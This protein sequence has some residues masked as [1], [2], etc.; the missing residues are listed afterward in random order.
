MNTSLQLAIRDRHL[1]RCASRIPVPPI[2][3]ALQ[4]AGLVLDHGT[5]ESRIVPAIVITCVFGIVGYLMHGV[6]RSGAVAGTLLAFIIYVGLGLGG[7]LSL[8]AVFGI[9]WVTTRIG[10]TRKRQLGLAEDTRGRNAGQV[11]AN[12]AVAAGFSVIAIFHRAFAFA[13]VAALA[14]AAADTASS[15]LGEVLAR[16]SRLITTFK[17]VDPG[18][19][20]GVSVTGTLAAIAAAVAIARIAGQLHV[21]HPGLWWVVAVSGFFGTLI[22][23]LLGATLER[24]HRLNNNTVNLLSTFGAGVVAL[25]ILF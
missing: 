7:F 9:T 20:G 23:S 11:L 8:L 2:L 19:N 12:L 4:S 18:T 21:I 22:D 10:F 13:A 6:T 16:R 15:E 1:I 14:E 24:E 25:A 3:V 17:V 5:P